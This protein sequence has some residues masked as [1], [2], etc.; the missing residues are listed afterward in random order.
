MTLTNLLLL[1]ILIALICLIE[2]A[3]RGWFMIITSVLAL[4]AYWV[5]TGFI[6]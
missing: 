2:G 3:D 5:V 4:S 6:L 1:L